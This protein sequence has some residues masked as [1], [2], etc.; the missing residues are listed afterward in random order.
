MERFPSKG[1]QVH[2]SFTR[3]AY[4][5]LLKR[6]QEDSNNG[7]EEAAFRAPAPARSSGGLWLVPVCESPK[8][9]R[10]STRW[11]C[12]NVSKEL[13]THARMELLEEDNNR[14]QELA[15]KLS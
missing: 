3:Q 8:G 13:A 4:R 1:D 7:L 10:N 11:Q 6:L 15:G 2:F 14:A 12:G 9:R 5:R